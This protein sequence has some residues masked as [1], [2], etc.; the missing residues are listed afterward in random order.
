[1]GACGSPWSDHPGRRSEIIL[2][3]RPPQRGQRRSQ[4]A[5]SF[6]RL[7]ELGNL[8]VRDR[9][10]VTT[11]TSPRRS[12]TPGSPSSHRPETAALVPSGPR[13]RPMWSPSAELRWSSPV[14]G[15]GPPS[16]PGQ[17]RVGGSAATRL[18]QPINTR[19]SQ[20]ASARRPTCRST[21][22]RTPASR[23]TRSPGAVGFRLVE[24]A[25]RVRSGRA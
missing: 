1:M 18:S 12:A 22:T 9:R 14:R 24:P 21:P 5:R 16:R 3:D 13:L 19:S 11:I 7:D 20:P 4:H 25:C 15:L 10:P 6:G 17:V 23:S 8:G 2:D